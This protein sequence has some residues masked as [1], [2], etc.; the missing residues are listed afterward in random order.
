MPTC[1]HHPGSHVAHRL[2]DV[3]RRDAVVRHRVHELVDQISMRPAVAA[4]DVGSGAFAVRLHDLVGE[5]IAHLVD[6]HRDGPLQVDPGHVLVAPAAA[7]DPEGLG[8]AVADLAEFADAADGAVGH[9]KLGGLV[10]ELVAIERIAARVRVPQAA[11]LDHVRAHHRDRPTGRVGRVVHGAGNHAATVVLRLQPPPLGTCLA[12][13]PAAL[14]LAQVAVRIFHV[15]E[16]LALGIDEPPERALGA[17]PPAVHRLRPIERGLT[18]HI[19]EPGS[20]HRPDQTVAPVENFVSVRDRDDRHGAVHVLAGLQCRKRLRR[21]QPRLRDDRHRVQVRRAQLIQGS[22]GV[23]GD[24]LVLER[25]VAGE[26]LDALGLP[27]AQGDPVDQRMALEQ[28][29][30]GGAEGAEARD[31]QR[32]P[33]DL[34]LLREKGSRRAWRPPALSYDRSVSRIRS[35]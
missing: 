9:P 1:G 5:R 19:V 26:T 7:E 27:I 10:A 14:H 32:D 2:P 16:V 34:S 25:R 12:G 23:G 13:Q 28:V 30:K 29:G 17:P 15:V 33:H 11:H 20:L 4:V 8:L 31:S 18:E 21:V 35:A 22:V 6:R 24:E 3:D